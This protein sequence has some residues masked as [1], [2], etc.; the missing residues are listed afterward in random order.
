MTQPSPSPLGLGM[1]PCSGQACP[2]S[3]AKSLRWQHKSHP[4]AGHL[5]RDRLEGGPGLGFV[6]IGTSFAPT[7][8]PGVGR[9]TGWT[10]VR[11]AKR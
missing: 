9:R 3:E 10:A 7:S 8:E 1:P 6:G 5:G 4:S 2:V 11:A